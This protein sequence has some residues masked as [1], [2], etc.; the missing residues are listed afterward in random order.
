MQ[1]AVIPGASGGGN[2]RQ[3]S[4][5]GR[6]SDDGAPLGP[7]NDDA[8]RRA[9]KRRRCSRSRRAT[10]ADPKPGG[11]GHCTRHGMLRQRRCRPWETQVAPAI[12]RGVVVSVDGGHTRHGWLHRPS[13]TNYSDPW[14]RRR[15]PVTTSSNPVFMHTAVGWAHTKIFSLIMMYDVD[16]YATF[17][18]NLCFARYQSSNFC[19]YGVETKVPFKIC[20]HAL[21]THTTCHNFRS[22]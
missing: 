17:C 14:P 7:S 6:A 21:E 4:R 2:G 9:G 16:I 15:P 19:V 8:P 22:T 1:V 12:V 5:G 18:N 13:M 10:A 20:A 11:D 3:C